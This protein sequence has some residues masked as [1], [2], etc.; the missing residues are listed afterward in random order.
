MRLIDSCIAQLEAQG[1][2]RTCD[3][4]KEEEEGQDA[5]QARVRQS[6][7]SGEPLGMEGGSGRQPLCMEEASDCWGGGAPEGRCGSEAGS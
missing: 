3:E 5:N 7:V 4:S 6:L 1:P 2:S